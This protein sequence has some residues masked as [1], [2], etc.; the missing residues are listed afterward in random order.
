ML[1]QSEM[2]PV[3]FELGVSI[4]NSELAD[5]MIAMFLWP[6]KL[7]LRGN[8]PMS[9]KLALLPANRPSPAMTTLHMK[10][11]N[12]LVHPITIVARC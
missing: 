8:R 12:A 7:P 9:K 1:L 4:K 6:F 10:A 11:P 3:E 5:T 2:Q